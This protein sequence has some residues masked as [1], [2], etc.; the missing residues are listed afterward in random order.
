LLTRLSRNVPGVPV[1]AC[2]DAIYITPERGRDLRA[3][4][5][6]MAV[7]GAGLEGDRYQLGRGSFSR[8][9]GDGRA[10]SLIAAEA[11]EAIHAETGLDLS[12]GRSRRNIVTRG[13]DVASLN[14]RKFRIGEAVFRGTRLCTPCKYLERLIGPGTFEALK[15]RGG[16]RA[17]ILETGVIRAGD[18]I[19]AL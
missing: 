7:A 18:E 5:E 16:L 14:G 10:V 1:A 12:S 6:I 11:I 13:I 2:V 3:V 9:P 8:W 19:V 17:D 15:G 4:G